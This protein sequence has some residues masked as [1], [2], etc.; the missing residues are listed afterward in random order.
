MDNK[1]ILI[2]NILSEESF[3][4]SF[5]NRIAEAFQSIGVPHDT[6]HL[7]GLRNFNLFE[8]YT[9]LMISGS[10]ESAAEEND[11]YPDLDA[12]IGRFL[13]EDKSILGICFG[14]QFLV[15]HILGKEHVRKSATPEVGWTEI[16]LS[17]NLLFRGMDSFKSGVFHYDE[18]FGL[19]E[20]FEITASSSRC[21]VH[22]FQVKGRPVWGVQFHPDFMY[23]DVF[24]FAE[25][26][27]KTDERFESFHCRTL[28]TPEEFRVN[29]LIF[30][31]WVE[32]S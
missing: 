4:T 15:R 30:K 1:Q 5:D 12:I 25:A 28:I 32:L 10:T 29:D 16:A 27:R 22:G 19:D 11:W 20:R 6:V 7:D 21:A 2:L 13:S 24:S 18:V 17:D 3:R 14:H 23:D 31:N 8:K 26:V 9:H